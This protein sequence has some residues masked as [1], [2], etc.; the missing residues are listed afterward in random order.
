MAAMSLQGLLITW[1]LVGVLEESAS[2]YGESRALINAAP[3]VILLI[4]GFVGDRVDAR[5][6]L[7]TLSLLVSMVPLLLTFGV[8]TLSTWMVIAFG[9]GTTLLSSLADPAKQGMINRVSKFDVQRSIALV[10][11]VPSLVGIAAMSLGTQ[12]ER[13]G[14]VAVLLILGGIY[15]CAAMTV[16][17]L[18]DL[19][20]LKRERVKVIDGFKSILQV[21]IVRRL[22]GMNFVSAIFNAGGYMVVMPYILMEYYAGGLLPFG[23]DTLLTMMFIAF[24][25]GS[26]GSTIALFWLM[27]LTNPG[28]IYISMQLFRVFV[29]VGIWLQPNPWLFMLF[30]MLW[31]INM[32]ITSTLVRSTI[33]EMAPPEHRTKVLGFYLFTFTL[34]SIIASFLLGHIVEWLGSLTA[35]LPGVLISIGL[36]LYGR[37]FSGYWVYRSP[38]FSQESDN[39]SGFKKASRLS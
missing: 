17:G 32:G 3:M 33:Q 31:G 26:T 39:L 29:I 28:K 25:V 12:L 38:S 9:A 15:A 21:S 24:T 35:L 2:V 22:M 30:V 6:Y 18:P 13:F 23:D 37:Y 27:P 7:F 16:L 1:I 11:I 36:F 10:T 34:S 20:P 5:R 8:A 4:G 19:P 14:L